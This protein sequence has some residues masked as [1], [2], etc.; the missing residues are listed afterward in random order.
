MVSVVALYTVCYRVCTVPGRHS[1][2]SIADIMKKRR[3]TIGELKKY[4]GWMPF[5][6]RIRFPLWEQ[7][8]RHYLFLDLVPISHID[9]KLCG[10]LDQPDCPVTDSLLTYFLRDCWTMKVTNLSAIQSGSVSPENCRWLWIIIQTNT[11]GFTL[12]L[13]V[14]PQCLHLGAL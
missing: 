7:R 11:R 13:H 1:T 6:L 9:F 4:L 14:W 12:S 5:Q 10:D 3:A 8:M 2:Y